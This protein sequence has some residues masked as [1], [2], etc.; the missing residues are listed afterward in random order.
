MKTLLV[1]GFGWLGEE[2]QTYNT[3]PQVAGLLAGI[4]SEDEMAAA[5]VRSQSAVAAASSVAPAADAAAACEPAA[6]GPGWLWR[7]EPGGLD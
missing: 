3:A 7:A 2:I 5:A 1:P 6:A 4:D